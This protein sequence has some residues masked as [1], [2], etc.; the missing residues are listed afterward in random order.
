MDPP[1]LPSRHPALRSQKKPTSAF[2]MY[3]LR[4]V[5]CYE[6][7]VVWRLWITF[8]VCCLTLFS[9]EMLDVLLP[10]NPGAGQRWVGSVLVPNPWPA[11]QVFSRCTSSA[12]LS[13]STTKSASQPGCRRPRRASCRAAKAAPVVYSASASG[14]ETASEGRSGGASAA[15]LASAGRRQ[16]VS[17]Y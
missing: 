12:T 1:L 7:D 14:K 3:M 11:R 10:H 5:M 8:S 16:N 9:Q 13:L 4:T 6:L 17:T 2:H 15:G